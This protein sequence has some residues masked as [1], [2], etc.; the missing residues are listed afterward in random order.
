[1]TAVVAGLLMSVAAQAATNPFVEDFAADNANWRGLNEVTPLNWNAAGGPDGSSYASGDWNFL[2]DATGD[3]RAPNKGHDAFDSSGD[4]FVGNWLADG[5]SLFTVQVRHNAPT[6]LTYFVR[7]ATD[8]PGAAGIAVHPAPVLP[9]T[10]TAI[11]IPIMDAF[12]FVSF[13]ASNFNT[14]FSQITKVQITLEVPDALA[15]VDQSFAFDVDKVSIVPEPA[16]LGMMSLLGLAL[17][18]RR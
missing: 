2:N 14:V 9:N 8:I 7:F 5:V 3:F 17:V 4:A 1:M 16:T 12:P 11:S 10:W 15:G 13:E 6:P 18:R